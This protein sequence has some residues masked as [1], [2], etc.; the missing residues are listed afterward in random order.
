MGQTG[1]FKLWIILLPLRER[2]RRKTPLQ[3]GRTWER[4]A[5][6]T[7]RQ[8]LRQQKKNGSKL[9]ACGYRCQLTFAGREGLCRRFRAQ[10]PR[11]GSRVSCVPGSRRGVC[12]LVSLLRGSHHHAALH[13][14]FPKN[15]T[16][17]S[18]TQAWW[19]RVRAAEWLSEGQLDL[20]VATVNFIAGRWPGLLQSWNDER[21]IVWSELIKLLESL[22]AKIRVDSVVIKSKRR[23][24]SHGLGSLPFLT[25]GKRDIAGSLLAMRLPH[26]SGISP[27]SKVMSRN[28]ETL[29]ALAMRGVGAC[30]FAVRLIC[31]R[32]ITT[33]KRLA[34]TLLSWEKERSS[35]LLDLV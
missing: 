4:N 7:S 22:Y 15:C 9:E 13:C 1:A 11:Y 19:G 26:A 31:F 21:K 10:R 28:S 3:G 6:N 25:V 23:K 30:F 35:K 20:I 8:I 24:S 12:V 32:L 27:L 5:A 18:Q 34:F 33:L 2:K 17:I 16:Q 14:C 29:L